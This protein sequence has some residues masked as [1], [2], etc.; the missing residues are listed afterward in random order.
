MYFIP[1]NNLKEGQLNDDPENQ[2]NKAAGKRASK[3]GL[4]SN[5]QKIFHKN[6]RIPTGTGRQVRYCTCKGRLSDIRNALRTLIGGLRAFLFGLK[7]SGY[8]NHFILYI[9][10]FN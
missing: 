10:S 9:S 8:F 5:S 4:R 1:N 6:C 7:K 3:A 2:R